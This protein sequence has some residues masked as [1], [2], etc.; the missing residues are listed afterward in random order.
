[1][2]RLTSVVYI[3]GARWCCG[4]RLILTIPISGYASAVNCTTLPDGNYELGCR[5]FAKCV[6]GQVSIVDCPDKM[7]YSNNTGMCDE[8]VKPFYS[9]HWMFHN[10]C[11]S[12]NI[13]VFLH[14]W[15]VGRSWEFLSNLFYLVFSAC[16]F[17]IVV[18]TLKLPFTVNLLKS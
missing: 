10:K 9:K 8:Y 1:M 15:K 18:L 12:L 6:G 4:F 14:P 7:V 16:V 17:A 2:S 5:S 3:C 11:F 13:Q